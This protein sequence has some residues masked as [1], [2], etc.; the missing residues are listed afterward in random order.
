MGAAIMAE[1]LRE[2]SGTDGGVRS[3]AGRGIP[4]PP[5]PKD[6]CSRSL[7]MIAVRAENP[8]ESYNAVVMPSNTEIPGKVSE[9]FYTVV[10]NQRQLNMS[11][12]EGEGEDLDFVKIIGEGVVNIDPHPKGSPIEVEFEYDANQMINARAYDLFNGGRKYLGEVQIKRKANLD[13]DQ[14]A[15]MMALIKKTTVN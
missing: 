13:D 14:V 7:G 10:E 15:G 6:V 2:S 4:L 12:T 1:I 9:T 8:D 11:I 5:A 3:S